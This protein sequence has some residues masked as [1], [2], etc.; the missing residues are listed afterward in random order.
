MRLLISLISV[1]MP[2]FQVNADEPVR[3]K[4]KI[5]IPQSGLEKLVSDYD[6][7]IERGGPDFIFGY[8]TQQEKSLLGGAGIDFETLYDDYRQE[9]DWVLSLFDF[10][11]YHTHQEVM[12]FLDSVATAHPSICRLDTLGE[13]VD[14]RAIVGM[15]IS[16]NPLVEEDEPEV[17][18]MGAHHG[19]E[20]ISVELPLYLIDYLTTRY[21]NDI[22]VTRLVNDREIFILPMVNPDGVTRNSRYNTHNQDLNRDYLCPEGDDCPSDADYQHSFSEPETQ[23][24][25]D[26]AAA[27][28]YVL[29]LSLHSGA[30]NINTV[31]NYDDGLHLNYDYHETPD[32]ALIMDLSYGYA[33]LNTTSGFYVTNGC[34]WYSTHGDANDFSYGYF[35]DIDWTIEISLIKT[36]PQNQIDDYWIDNQAAMLY[37]IDAADIGVRGI[38][39]DS[40]T[41]EFL[42][43]TIRVEEGGLPLFTD[44]QIGDYHRP[45]LPGVYHIRAE[46]PGYI[47]A[48]SGPIEVTTGPA[49]VLDFRLTPAQMAEF[50]I[51]VSDSLSGEPLAAAV[52]IVSGVVDT[53]FFYDGSPVS[54][55]LDSDIYDISVFARGHIPVFDHILL[56]GFS[57]RDY[58]LTDYSNDLFADDFEGSPDSWVFGGSQ[59]HWGIADGGFM[60]DHS[61]QDSPG[62]YY[63]NTYSY[64]RIDSIFDLSQFE[65]A[66]FYFVEKHNL[67]PYYDFVFP[68]ISVNGGSLW[69]I[70]PDTLTG[71]ANPLWSDHF[72]S[73]DNY[74][75]QG[76]DNISLRFRFFSGPMVNYDG[77][78]I[79]D[80]YLGGRST[81]S[82]I[83][84]EDRKPDRIALWQNYPNPFNMSTLISVSGINPENPP[85][86]EIF[87]VLGRHVCYLGSEEFKQ[88]QYLWGG[89]DESGSSV[90]SGIYFYRLAGQNQVRAMTLLK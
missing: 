86:I 85:T 3:A 75:G 74:C 41:G 12:F 65:S 40:L 82:D 5:S 20:K 48:E 6:L 34:D 4:I 76:F 69:N 28:R 10:G 66:G 18:I 72:V 32:D 19:D 43:A 56:A 67:Q 46:S 27:N 61:L 83:G 59:N 68:E 49:Q 17:R 54:L 78:Y 87:D 24:V 11:V 15:R 16:D 31:W 57:T 13:S 51:T 9:S 14:R 80:F 77:A 21:G 55:T 84:G 26:D 50:D 38:I 81:P 64:A 29:S 36:P 58:S 79:D 62:N 2:V 30:T 53:L 90:S 42:D 63:S 25:R 45:L 47:S 44:A 23:V 70:L 60:S 71:Y 73:L 22:D 33:D 7:D 8:V 39:S 1:I 35:S 52:R 88:G 37:I 89:L